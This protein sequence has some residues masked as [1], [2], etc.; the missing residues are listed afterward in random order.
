MTESIEDLLQ[1]ID[2]YKKDFYPR[3][4][5]LHNNERLRKLVET[6]LPWGIKLVGG[7][8]S[9]SDELQYLAKGFTLNHKVCTYV[10]DW[11]EPS[12]YDSQFKDFKI[13]N[14]I[15]V[16]GGKELLDY[17]PNI[18]IEET[19]KTIEESIKNA[20]KNL[21]IYKRAKEK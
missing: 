18:K 16:A 15:L 17:F 8:Y 6:Y 9:S 5:E 1:K 12:R 14:G 13:N 10:G 21:D 3:A 19:N 7:E 11:D 4:I 20:I 2:D